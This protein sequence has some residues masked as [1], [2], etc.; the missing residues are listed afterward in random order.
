[1]TGVQTC[2]LPICEAGREA[3]DRFYADHRDEPLIVDKWFALQAMSPAPQTLDTVEALMK[4]PAFSIGNPNRVRSLVGSFATGNMTQ[5][6]RRDGAG[7]RFLARIVAAL[8]A[9]NPQVAA[10]L[11]AAL[12]S[13]RDLEPIRQDAARRAL[14]SVRAAAAS[15]DVRDIVART[16][17]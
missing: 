6:N 7:Y 16:L 17:A 15:P 3:L 12:R 10:R 5:F 11:L 13:W 8:D 2:A 1:M 9:S 14:E 4:H